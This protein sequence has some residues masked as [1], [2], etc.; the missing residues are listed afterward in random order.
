MLNGA[1]YITVNNLNITGTGA[2]Y[3]LSCHLWNNAD[4]NNFNNCTFTCPAN[5]TATTHVPFSISGT[6]TTGI[7][8]GT[9][10]GSN[11]IITNCNTVS[12]YYN[13]CVVGSSTLPNTGNQV[14]NCH[15]QD[16]Y[17]YGIYCTYQNG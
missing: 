2:T 16:F 8:T 4:Y 7:G 5:G 11:N 17:F 12:G 6:A 13:L 9:A 1:D 15:A 14:I 10:C 3:A